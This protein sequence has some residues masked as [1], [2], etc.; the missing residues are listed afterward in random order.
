MK[1][2]K[3]LSTVLALASVSAAWADVSFRNHRYDSMKATPITSNNIVFVG[4]SITNMHEWWEAFGSNHNVA[5]RGNSGGMSGELVDNIESYIS[6]KPAKLFLMIGTNDIS[7]GISGDVVVDNI[8]TMLLRFKGESPSTELYVQ[9]ILPR[10]HEPQNTNNAA[11]NVKLRALC[12]ELGVTYVDLWDALQG[13]RNYGEWSADGLHLYAAGYR[14]WCRIIEQYVGTDCVYLDSYTNLGSGMG[15]ATAMRSSY[16]GM[17]PLAENDAII[18]GDEMI[19][20]G[21]WHELLRTPNVKSRGTLWGYGGL[22]LD[23]HKAQL[24]TI[25]TGNGNKKT[26]AKIFFYCGTAD[27]N[28]TKYGALI[29]EAQRLAPASKLYIISQIP[30]STEANTTAMANFN[31]QLQSL[32]A[33]K[34]ATYVDVYSG[35]V[36]AAGNAADSR[37]ITGDYLYGRGYIVVANKLAEYLQEEGANPVTMAEFEELYS[38]RTA[39]TAL[40]AVINKALHIKFGTAVGEYPAA[41]RA[42]LDQTVEQ[43]YAVLRADSFDQTAADAAA[44]AIN[45]AIAALG[46]PIAPIASTDA[47]EHLYTFVSSLRGGYYTTATATGVAGVANT[48]RLKPAELLWKFV[49]RADGDFDIVNKSTGTY[50]SPTAGYNNQIQLVAT[51]P[52]AGWRI[53]TS[54][55]AGMFTIYSGTSC[56]LNQTTLSGLPVYNWYSKNVAF[57]DQTD[58][59]CQLSIAEYTDDIYEAALTTG[60]YEIELANDLEGYVT[61]GTHHMLNA[62]NEYRQNSTNYYALKFAAAPAEEFAPRAW[63]HLTVNGANV[64]VTGANGHGIMEN[65]TSDRASLSTNNPAVAETA[66]EGVFTI[67]KWSYFAPT[68]GTEKPYV[69]KSSAS[70]NSYRITRVPTRRLADFDVYTVTMLGATNAAEIGNDPRLTLAADGL[71]KGISSVY[72]GGTIFVPAGTELSYTDFTADASS[73]QSA[74][75]IIIDKELLTI[76]VD[77]N[78]TQDQVKADLTTGWY[79]IEAVAENSHATFATIITDGTHHVLNVNNEYRQNLRGE[80]FHY[81]LKFGAVP[82]EN[83]ALA[84]VHMKRVSSGVYQ[85]TSINGHAVAENV[86]AVLEHSTATHTTVA[87]NADYTAHNIGHWAV[88]EN[89]GDESPY[90]GKFSTQT[91]YFKITPVS[92]DDLG[93]YDIYTVKMTGISP[94]ANINENPRVTLNNSASHA[95]LSQVYNNGMFFMNKGTVPA[96]ADLTADAHADND[97]P[98]ITVDPAEKSIHVDYTQT[99]VPVGITDVTVSEADAD[100]APYYNLQGIRV[101]KPTRS[102]IYIH[103]GV[104]IRF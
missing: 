47:E 94:A 33:E 10:V 27:Q 45:T 100:S 30:R 3:L 76:T 44:A 2:R 16:F 97:N 7:T 82:A 55:T 22:T 46:A 70:N 99:A 74:P 58:A 38:T 65:C 86:T 42:G 71:S 28:I 77:Y 53:G 37:Y 89:D 23:Q 87:A 92:S 91:N 41:N 52:A 19:H 34:G 50:V 24:S 78:H 9:S 103:N 73:G 25:L 64:Q 90:V 13:V 32:A 83:P 31:T 1:F 85:I 15:G 48:Q 4:N 68:D 12:Q 104:K 95:A 40:G 93:R 56:Q 51:S 81:P 54:G 72:N 17:L 43:A 49:L 66:T 88:Y 57:P 80:L 60:W 59:G 79:E 26:P 102:G 8:R 39:R 14:T 29:D 5:N 11:A 20:G 18:V 21:E 63:I 69:G 84:Y 67:G 75:A 98:L 36:N 96:V 101:A 6:G 62:D 35:L 61:A